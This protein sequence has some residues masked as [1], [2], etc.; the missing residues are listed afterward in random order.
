MYTHLLLYYFT[1]TGNSHRVATWMAE[2][3]RLRGIPAHVSAMDSARPREELCGPGKLV[4]LVG[5]THGFTAPWWMIRFALR[6][7][8]GRGAHAFSLAN[9]A[10]TKFG[11]LFVP[12]LEGTAAY[13]LALILRLKGYH[14]RG[15]A[16]LDMPSNWTVVHPSLGKAAVEAIIAR[17]QPRALG[18][19]ERMLDGGTAFW[20]RLPLVFGLLLLPISALYMVMGRFFLSRLFYA[21]SQCNG[22]GLC[23][24]A[25]PVG[26]IQMKGRADP[27][28]Y[29]TFVCV[30]CTRCMNY[31]PRGAVEASYP[32]GALMVY[33]ANIPL[34]ALLLDGLARWFA[35]AAGLKGTLVEWIIAYPYKLLSIAAAYALFSL[36]LRLP[37]F[38]RLV[39]LLTPTH[40]YRRY[41]EP[42]ARLGDLK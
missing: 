23:A 12:G 35:G 33:L 11:R 21:S 3:A 24:R 28:P 16:G 39:T 10:G 25:C 31:C 9:R 4:G 8:P 42:G 38:N 41:H 2:A 26:G 27:R 6:L 15:A 17:A 7:P 14:V 18:F 32:L 13:L 37:F 34:A 40:Y 19:L 20:S 22:C 5:P 1:G 36:C 30:A 29:W